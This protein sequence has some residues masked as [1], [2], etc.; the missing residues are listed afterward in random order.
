M[1]TFPAELEVILG[2][3]GLLHVVY[4]A[5]CFPNPVSGEAEADF[6]F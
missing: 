5:L 1:T 4:F 2:V 3:Q 6:V